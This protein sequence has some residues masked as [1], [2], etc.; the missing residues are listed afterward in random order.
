MCGPRGPATSATHPTKCYRHGAGRTPQTPGASESTAETWGEEGL[1]PHTTP[2]ESGDGRD[3]EGRPVPSG[4]VGNEALPGGR[5]LASLSPHGGCSLLQASSPRWPGST[6]RP[7]IGLHRT[8][9]AGSPPSS[10]LIL[11]LVHTPVATKVPFPFGGSSLSQESYATRT[12]R[13]GCLR[14]HAV[15]FYN[16]RDDVPEC[17]AGPIVPQVGQHT[18]VRGPGRRAEWLQVR[19]LS[20]PAWS[21]QGLGLG[22]GEHL[23][24][25]QGPQGSWLAGTTFVPSEVSRSPGDSGTPPAGPCHVFLREPCVAGIFR[26]ALDAQR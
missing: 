23:P 10:K 18:E 9:E 13:G 22:L 1:E 12:V 21:L 7:S 24:A 15:F 11:T 17:W 3:R 2:A 5:D 16:W 25:F 6:A 4:R 19:D 8:T 14:S 26:L 20:P